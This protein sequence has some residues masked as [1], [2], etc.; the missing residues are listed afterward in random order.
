[1]ESIQYIQHQYIDGI[2]Y[3]LID[4]NISFV[5]LLER[6]TIRMVY[7]PLFAFQCIHEN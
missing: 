5:N 6:K 2:W 1:M 3:N 7:I 4:V